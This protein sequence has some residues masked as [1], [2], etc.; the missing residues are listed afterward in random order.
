LRQS[1]LIAKN[2]EEAFVA[3]KIEQPS[4]RSLLTRKG[5]K[6]VDTSLLVHQVIE[7]FTTEGIEQ[8]QIVRENCEEVVD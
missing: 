5:K 1:G 6:T 7:S 3:C 4:N 2:I 8:F